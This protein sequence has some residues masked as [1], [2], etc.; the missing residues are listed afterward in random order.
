MNKVADLPYELISYIGEF[1]N[2]IWEEKNHVPTVVNFIRATTMGITLV[3]C[4]L[5]S[6]RTLEINA[7]ILYGTVWRVYK[8]FRDSLTFQQR[9]RYKN[10]K[11][12]WKD[13]WFQKHVRDKVLPWV[14]II[15]NPSQI[16]VR[17]TPK[18]K[19]PR[20]LTH[21]NEVWPMVNPVAAILPTN[22]T[23]AQLPARFDRYIILPQGMDSMPEQVKERIQLM[24]TPSIDDEDLYYVHVEPPD[25]RLL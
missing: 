20:N 23:V 10:S 21:I 15:G 14:P 3:E 16:W 6:F 24:R 5:G 7:V 1:L 12:E 11:G 22:I 17:S 13:L 4:G 18:Q 8:E 19:L 2:P 25:F 9:W